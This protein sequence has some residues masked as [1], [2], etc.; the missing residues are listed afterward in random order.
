MDAAWYKLA[1]M[2]SAVVSMPDGTSAAFYQ[3][4]NEMFREMLRK[5]VEI[6]ERLYREW[7]QLARRYQESLGD[8]TSP[9]T[10]AETFAA[11]TEKS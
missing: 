7:P 6:H 3:R 1:T 8:I 4:D 5:T 9:E 10:W 2:D 11:S